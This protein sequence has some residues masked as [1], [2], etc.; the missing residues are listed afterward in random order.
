MKE[1]QIVINFVI[2]FYKSFLGVQK[3]RFQREEIFGIVRKNDDNLLVYFDVLKQ[4]S[5]KKQCL[6]VYENMNKFIDIFKFLE[7]VMGKIIYFSQ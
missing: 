6:Y 2:N 3:F 1:K 7:R 4:Y 5:L